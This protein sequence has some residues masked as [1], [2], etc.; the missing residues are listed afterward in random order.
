MCGL[1][2]IFAYQTSAD[3]PDE[4][5]LIAT[6]DHMARRGPDGLGAWWSVDRRL[7]LGH[8]RLSIQDVSDRALQPMVG[9]DGAHVVVYNG[10]IYNFPEL[11][12]EL[13]AQGRHFRTTSD[14]EVLLHLYAVHGQA[15]VGRLRGMYAFAIWD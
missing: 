2:G 10:E 15:M 14:T 1:N 11:R 5:E 6:R 4:A 13:Q 7:A 12:A 9:A 8:R 3:P